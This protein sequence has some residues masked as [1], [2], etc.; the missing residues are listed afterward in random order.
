MMPSLPD[1]SR[2][3]DALRAL[4]NAR[5]SD[6][7][8]PFIDAAL[9]ALESPRTPGLGGPAPTPDLSPADLAAFLDHTQLRPAATSTDIGA[10][11]DEAREH[12]FATVCIPPNA[13]PHA[14]ERLADTDVGVCTVVG[15]PHGTSRSTVKA[16]EAARA[17]GDGADEVDMVLPIG[18]LKEGRVAAVASDVRAVV[19][20]VHTATDDGCVK[21]ILET[22]L[23]TDAEI[24]VAC[25]AVERA[26]ADFVKTSTGFASAG[27][28]LPH[29]ALM[30][31]M[32]GDALGVKAAGGVGS[33]A[34]ALQM[35]AHGATR[36][37]AS[38]SVS[39]VTD[40]AP[41][42]AS[43]SASPY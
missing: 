19:D 23:L 20:A 5:S 24:A 37:G 42:S 11:C 4:R 40:A 3:A 32:V 13:V 34:D 25:V 39:I 28:T 27:A 14:T 33:A 29:V 31:Q 2:V 43:S 38:G 35:I 8:L 9:H 16:Y 6:A 21:V 1:P 41:A 22:A 17:V 30:R 7:A 18:L 12:G 36:I 15:F 26:G 10:V